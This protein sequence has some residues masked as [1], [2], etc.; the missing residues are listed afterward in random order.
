MVSCPCWH[1]ARSNQTTQLINRGANPSTLNSQPSTAQV[2][3]IGAL[4]T[5]KDG[6]TLAALAL[7]FRA[8]IRSLLVGGG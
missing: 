6:D 1:S 3:N 8:D 4:Y 5:S 7:R 2:I